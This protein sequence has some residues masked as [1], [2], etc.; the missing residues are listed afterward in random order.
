MPAWRYEPEASGASDSSGM[1]EL[2]VL[3]GIDLE[4]RRGEV[5]AITGASGAG[6]ST[7]LQILGTLDRPTAGDIEICDRNILELKGDDLAGFSQCGTSV[8]SFSFTIC[9]RN[10]RLWRTCCCRR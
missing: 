5:L 3:K 1:E 2:E 6:K 4:V 8:S 10:S 9:Y 7:L